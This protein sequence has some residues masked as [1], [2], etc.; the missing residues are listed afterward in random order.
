MR[1][2]AKICRNCSKYEER[3]VG[4]IE[5]VCKQSRVFYTM[6]NILSY[7]PFIAKKLFEKLD[8]PKDCELYAEYCIHDWN[9]NEKKT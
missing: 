4:V 2:K 5:C 7:E 6:S 9:K 1:R 8:I 3:D